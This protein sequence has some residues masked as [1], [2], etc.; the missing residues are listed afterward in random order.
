MIY[1]IDDIDIHYIFPYFTITEQ[2]ADTLGGSPYSEYHSQVPIGQ[3][4]PRLEIRKDSEQVKTQNKITKE[5][6]EIICKGCFQNI[7]PLEIFFT[8]FLKAFF[9]HPRKKS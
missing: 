6:I 7:K 3:L 5:D 1:I 9:Y 8:P 2:V 4:W